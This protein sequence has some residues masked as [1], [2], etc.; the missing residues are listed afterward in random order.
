MKRGL[1]LL[2]RL[3]PAWWRSRYGGE[4]EALLEDSG[5]RNV[6]DVFRGAMEMQMTTWSFRRIVTVCAIVGVAV[7]AVAVFLFPPPYSSTAILRVPG[8]DK[9][10][11][12]LADKVND[13][14]V[15]AMARNSLAGIIVAQ[16]L[17]LQERQRMAMEDVIDKV[18][19]RDIHVA[20]VTL[21][22]GKNKIDGIEVRF[23]YWD[24][25]KTQEV[26]RILAN[27]FPGFQI[28]D[29]PSVPQRLRENYYRFRIALLGLLAGLIA[30]AG[31]ALFWRKFTWLST[32]PGEN[33]PPLKRFYL[34][35]AISVS[36]MT[37]CAIFAPQLFRHPLAWRFQRI[38]FLPLQYLVEG[39]G[40]RL[41]IVNIVIGF[42]F[43]ATTWTGILYAFCALVGS[44]LRKITPRAS[45]AG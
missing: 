41:T 20:L 36:A 27:R 21:T 18:M 45:S 4:L 23:D 2:I 25:S 26:A 32:K 13:A 33:L 11:S 8:E 16:N 22:N 34:S 3:Y 12:N 15:T 7:S 9:P 35:F 10:A 28:L 29:P 14:A 40:L 38:V 19:R 24:P 1:R 42:L 17:Y 5:S 37:F 43:S 30:G 31:L 6:W 39:F 44:T